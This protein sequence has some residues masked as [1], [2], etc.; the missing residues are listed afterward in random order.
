MEQ[1]IK[2]LLGQLQ[3]AAELHIILHSPAVLV[4]SHAHNKTCALQL[5]KQRSGGSHQVLQG[6]EAITQQPSSGTGHSPASLDELQ[7]ASFSLLYTWVL[8]ACH[9]PLSHA[10]SGP[11]YF[12]AETSALRFIPNNPYS[13]N[14]LVP[15]EGHKRALLL[16]K[17]LGPH[18]QC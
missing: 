7:Q 4:L 12:D 11:N 5:Q 10:A 16:H 9:H 14:S 2:Y 18:G 3:V 1:S 17:E 13:N 15:G 6:M 8:C